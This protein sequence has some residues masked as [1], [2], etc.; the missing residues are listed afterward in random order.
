M[1]KLKGSLA[2][3]IVAIVLLA[4]SCLA[5]CGA[6]AGISWL[7]GIGAYRGGKDEVR[8]TLLDDS[9]ENRLYPLMND[10]RVLPVNSVYTHSD[11][12]F[13][14]LD[15]DWNVLAGNLA[16]DETVLREMSYPVSGF[17]GGMYFQS[18]YEPLATV[19][20][21]NRTD[22]ALSAYPMMDAVDESAEGPSP[23]P[24]P[25]PAPREATAA[26]APP[27]VEELKKPEGTLVYFVRLYWTDC[28]E[29]RA[30]GTELQV[31]EQLHPFRYALIGVAVVSFVLAVL[32]F[33]FLMAAAGHHDETGEV[34]A[35]FVEKIPADLLLGICLAGMAGCWI[36]I[37]ETVSSNYPVASL[38]FTSLCLLAAGL[39][40]L[41]WL[42][43]A[44][45]RLKLGVFLESCLIWRVLRRCWKGIK[46]AFRAAG[47]LLK[48]VPL[49]WK[50][51]PVFV[52][53]MI[54]DFLLT[55]SFRR[56]AD[57]LFFVKL[58]EW[59][60]LAAAILY[61]ALCFQRLRKGAKAIA[62]GEEAVV[63]DEKYMIGDI[64]DH[65]EDLTHIRDGLSR[66][67]DERMKSER[68][69][70]E[71]ITN[72]SHDIKT[73]LT[74][75]VNYVDL[76]AREELNNEK[77]E[78]Y[79]EVL[80]RQSARLKKLTDDLVE[81]SKA[82]TGNLPVAAEKLELGVLLD[83]TAGEYGERL[84]EKQLEL[85]VT[86]PEEPVYVQADP[87]HLWRILDN[88][89]NNI[90]KYAL[91]GTRV[92]L[93]LQRENGKAALCFRNISAQPLNVKAEE[94]TERFV[95]GDSARST[96]G[97]GLGLAIAASLAKLQGIELDLSVDGDLFKLT[98]RF[99]EA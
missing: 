34:K 97:S 95:R 32:L 93:D 14:L 66:A 39:L 73:P 18:E 4:A 80:Q 72:V 71:L 11:V 86:K 75:I 10:L 96:E 92:Y 84:T 62:A 19:E 69:R 70:T 38:I 60:L 57:M 64:K 31:L 27:A 55:A 51:I 3:K 99:N 25:T 47:R 53:L 12:R 33:V 49:V 43:S 88:L 74:S 58:L 94:L 76:L 44:A 59:A 16:E 52:V 61:L 20:A 46:A 23:L 35:G 42:M 17:F 45:V 54:A 98:L 6:V 65:A 90:L 68:L 30:W 83:Q 15:K 22:E 1:N 2:A 26:A 7:D 85:R 50:W 48:G 91:P 41:L 28:C 5:L 78:E 29:Q 21:L 8:E 63:I 13:E 87:R 36:G 89:M 67:V 77:A 81:A 56:D 37:S 82:S 24:T 9:L 40:A 79:I